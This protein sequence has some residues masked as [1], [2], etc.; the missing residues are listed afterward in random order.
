GSKSVADSPTST[1]RGIQA[2]YRVGLTL[3]VSMLLVGLSWAL[4]RGETAAVSIRLGGLFTTG[5]IADRVVGL[6]ILV[7]S[8]T[9]AVV[10]MALIRAWWREGDRRFA[11][12]GVLVIAILALALVV[13]HG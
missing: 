8:L 3:A 7:L 4:L 9:P 10:V 1:A 2:I 13:G 5:S 6:G 11:A 12:S